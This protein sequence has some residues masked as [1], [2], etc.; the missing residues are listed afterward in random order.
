MSAPMILSLSGE[1]PQGATYSVFFDKLLNLFTKMDQEYSK[2]AEYYGFG[3]QGCSDNCCQTSFY[4]HTYL[5]YFFVHEGFTHLSSEEKDQIEYR[6]QDVLRDIAVADK[7]GKPVRLMCPLNFNGLCGLYF[8]RPM[9]CRLHGIPHELRKP[10]QNN[11]F[12]PGCGT[13]DERCCDKLYYEFDRTPFYIEMATLE[14]EFKQT[15]G[16]GGRIKLT[17]AEMIASFH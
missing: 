4:H 3:C 7:V 8:Y 13:F 11:I 17:V 15:V 5:E 12:G 16:V 14:N 6:A 1:P 9:I 2:A 10:G